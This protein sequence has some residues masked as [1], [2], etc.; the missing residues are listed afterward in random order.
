MKIYLK[1]KCYF[2]L[3]KKESFKFMLVFLPLKKY[4]YMLSLPLSLKK[5]MK[6]FFFL[7][8]SRYWKQVLDLQSNELD[9]S[10]YNF[11]KKS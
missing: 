3:K 10:I 4:L 8:L 2:D 11:E 9:L 6:I 1:K 5:I 7:N